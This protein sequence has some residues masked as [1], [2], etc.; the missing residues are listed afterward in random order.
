[1]VPVINPTRPETQNFFMNTPYIIGSTYL[2]VVAISTIISGSEY[3][4]FRK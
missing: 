2:F 1:M 4:K 3:V